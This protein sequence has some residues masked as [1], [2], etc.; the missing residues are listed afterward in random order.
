MTLHLIDTIPFLSNQSYIIL[1][2]IFY[3][4]RYDLLSYIQ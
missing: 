3:N 2:I 4:E 1:Y